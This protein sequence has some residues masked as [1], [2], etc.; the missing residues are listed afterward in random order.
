MLVT[1]L[2]TAIAGNIFVSIGEFVNRQFT[3]VFT[4]GTI[5]HTGL[6]IEITQLI[7]I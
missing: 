2:F 7:H 3:V 5:V 1:E 6:Q 4:A